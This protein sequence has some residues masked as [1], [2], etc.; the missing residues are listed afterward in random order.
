MSTKSD[1]RVLLGVDGE[2]EFSR[3]MDKIAKQQRE[4]K[5]QFKL[6]NSE[7]GASASSY[8][9]AKVSAE[10]LTKQIEVQKNKVAEIEAAYEKARTEQGE[11]SKTTIDL[12]HDYDTAQTVLNNLK[13]KLDETNKTIA[14]QESKFNKAG[15]ALQKYSDR[16]GKI[17]DGMTDVGKSLTKNVSV[18][19][20][21]AGVTAAKSA[22]DFESA[23][24]GVKKT[25]DATDEEFAQMSKTTLDMST[26]LATSAEEIAR[27][28]EVAGQ[29]GIAKGDIVN[30]SEVMIKLGMSTDLSAEEAAAALSKI[31][32]ITNMPSEKYE[33]L[34]NVIVDLGNKFSTT[35]ADIVD[36]T[37][38]LAATG[39]VVGYTQPQMFAIATALSSVGIEA[40][41]GGS[42]FSKLSKTLNLAVAKGGKDLEKWAKVAGVSSAD[43]KKAYEEDALGALNMF[44]K[45]L[46]EMQ[47]RGENSVAVLS[48]MGLTEVRLSNAVL[49]LASSEDILGSALEVANEQWEGGN[50]L[51]EEADKRLETTASKL[52]NA[53][54][55]LVKT[56]VILGDNFLPMIQD[57]AKNIGEL[58]ERFGELSPEQQKLIIKFG[59]IAATAGPTI[60]ALGKVSNGISAITGTGAKAIKFF[61]KI[62]TGTYTGPLKELV[63][64]LS[65]TG[66]EMGS[67]AAASTSLAS[68][69]GTG[70]PLIIAFAAAAAVAGG[71][72]LAYRKNTE[73]TR[74]LGS[75]IEKICS[76]FGNLDAEVEQATNLF[77]GLRDSVIGIDSE[78]Q[79]QLNKSIEDVQDQITEIARLKAN[80]RRELTQE[81]INRLEELF[82]KMGELSEAEFEM[83]SK[84]QDAVKVMAEN[85]K[86]MTKEEADS[87]IKTATDTKDEVIEL[88][89]KRCEETILLAQQA[90][91][92]E[93][94]ISKEEFDR[95]VAEATE[96]KERAVEAAKAKYGET[97]AVITDAFYNEQIATDEHYQR[98]SELTEQRNEK[99]KELDAITQ[100]QAMQNSL[101]LQIKAWTVAGEIDK[102][103][104][105]I[106]DSYGATNQEAFA[107]WMEMGMNAE[108]YGGKISDE[109]KK[110]ADNFIANFDILSSKSKEAFKNAMQGALDGLKEKES[111]LFNKAANV[112]DSFINKIK[113]KFDINSPSRVM[114]K[115]FEFAIQGGIVGVEKET[116]ELMKSADSLAEE[117]VDRFDISDDMAEKLKASAKGLAGLDVEARLGKLSSTASVATRALAQQQISNSKTLTSNS[118][119][120]NEYGGFVGFKIENMSVNSESD[121]NMLA[122][123]VVNELVNMCKAKGVKI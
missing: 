67:T 55:E 93:D 24:A 68:I 36:M 113:E 49:A 65:K 53:K 2:A 41:A 70:G 17:G 29:L 85:T 95:R 9:K 107:A 88:A 66:A 91:D 60:T 14:E 77:N 15:D 33:A 104:G 13:N 30:F 99:Q 76:N 92:Q 7:L 94:G 57:V 69:V 10:S 74:E 111:E 114:R 32:N 6:A 37:T 3:K 4:L 89:R 79:A 48:D 43:F 109:S 98:I 18:P 116:P 64:G 123:R 75:E 50:A 38:R 47:K 22:V 23:F 105:Q 119:T 81:E 86:T 51:Q 39:Q 61:G 1:L 54:G 90:Y 84:K 115:L 110:T 20:L 5:D 82:G 45:G 40:E 63:K 25:V 59:M 72:Y 117:F 120:T 52:Q 83:M 62:K 78:K 122:E 21:T 31:A 19:I 11:L 16:M 56:A 108:L 80:E 27:V 106:S 103:N 8:D 87:L 12:K 121:I 101:Y 102:I 44:I 96:E 34:G 97:Y 73:G 112:A 118:S 58:A 42:A 46:G 100:D 35:E 28:E 71:L 26:K